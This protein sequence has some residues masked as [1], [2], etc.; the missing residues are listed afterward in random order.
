[1]VNH[2]TSPFIKKSLGFLH[3]LSFQ[4]SRNSTRIPE[5][6][7]EKSPPMSNPNFKRGIPCLKKLI[8]SGIISID[9]IFEREKLRQ[10]EKTI[11]ICRNGHSNDYHTRS[12]PSFEGEDLNNQLDAV[13]QNIMGQLQRR[14]K[15]ISK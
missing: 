5:Q 8:C 9:S 3:L 1:M 4:E 6:L 15:N 11:F 13:R 7:R 2:F 12:R 10:I 14:S